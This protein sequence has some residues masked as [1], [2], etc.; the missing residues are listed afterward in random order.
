MLNWRIFV[1]S[2][3]SRI[4]VLNIDRNRLLKEAE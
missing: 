1:V 2:G 3:K 4:M